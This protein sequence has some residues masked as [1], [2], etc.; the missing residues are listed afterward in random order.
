MNQP[1]RVFAIN[2]PPEEEKYISTTFIKNDRGIIVSAFLLTLENEPGVGKI[3]LFMNGVFFKEDEKLF[4]IT[5]EM[6]TLNGNQDELSTVTLGIKFPDL[7]SVIGRS[8]I[9]RDGKSPDIREISGLRGVRGVSKLSTG[10]RGKRI[11]N[12]DWESEVDES[13]LHPLFRP[14]VFGNYL[15]SSVRISMCEGFSAQTAS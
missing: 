10:W 12:L 15:P 9:N 11:G 7:P 14:S 13:P 6:E 5:V 1:P 3:D 4:M 8:T 2:N